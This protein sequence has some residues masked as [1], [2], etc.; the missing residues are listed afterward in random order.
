M[1]CR[2]IELHSFHARRVGHGVLFKKF[3]LLSV[4][5][6]WKPKTIPCEQNSHSTSTNSSVFPEPL[7]LGAGVGTIWQVGQ[8]LPIELEGLAS[9]P[10]LRPGSKVLHQG[11]AAG[12]CAWAAAAFSRP[13][14][15]SCNMGA[16]SSWWRAV[17]QW[18][19]QRSGCNKDTASSCSAL[20]QLLTTWKLCHDQGLG[21]VVARQAQLLAPRP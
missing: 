13:L 3:F 12:S 10:A 8:I 21:K 4:L 15:P 20:V 6:F 7:R 11:Q 9:V 2:S 14:L 16:A 5:T 19:G 17:S 18:G 1:C